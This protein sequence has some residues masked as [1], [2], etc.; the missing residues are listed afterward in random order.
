[1]AKS[2]TIHNGE[3]H[4]FKPTFKTVIEDD[5]DSVSGIGA[6]AERAQRD[7]AHKWSLI[8][9]ERETRRQEEESRAKRK[10]AK[11]A[12]D[13]RRLARRTRSRQNHPTGNGDGLSASTGGLTGFIGGFLGIGAFALVAPGFAAGI[14]MG[15]S[16]GFGFWGV[17][18]SGVIT[19]G[20]MGLCAAVIVGL[21]GAGLAYWWVVIPLL[22]L[23]FFMRH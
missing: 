18:A 11:E 3:G 15:A 1:M 9:H 20:I 8:E 10:L 5:E 4:W 7:A 21:L 23:Y 6:T 22:L 12:R 16:D 2:R 14:F 19:A 17:I 13:T